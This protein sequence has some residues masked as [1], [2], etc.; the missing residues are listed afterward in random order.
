[1]FYRYAARS[2]GFGLKRDSVDGFE[3]IAKSYGN[4]DST[5]RADNHSYDGNHFRAWNYRQ[6]DAADERFCRGNATE[7]R[8]GICVDDS[9]F[10]RD[11]AFFFRNGQANV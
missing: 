10:A 3:N 1:V 7:N 11:A 9:D 6:N 5:F 8:G 4:S 2:G